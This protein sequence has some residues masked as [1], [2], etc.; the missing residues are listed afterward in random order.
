MALS[1]DPRCVDAYC[2]RGNARRC[3]GDDV[4]SGHDFETAVQ[5]D[6]DRGIAYIGRALAASFGHN[7]QANPSA[8]FEHGKNLLAHPLQA[9]D[10]VM[11]GTAKA[12]LHDSQGAIEDYTTAIGIDPRLVLAYNNRGNLRQ[13]LGDLDGALLDFSLG[14]KID[15][16]HLHA[17]YNRTITRSEI[18]DIRGAIEDLERASEL[19]PTFT[20]AYYQRGRVLS[21]NHKHQYAIGG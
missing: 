7:P 16:N 1:L 5:L 14:L 4:G 9:I 12:Q 3:L 15:S 6:P 18:G 11:R 21:M 19:N 13:Q 17:H 10:Y 8:D 20:M 2:G